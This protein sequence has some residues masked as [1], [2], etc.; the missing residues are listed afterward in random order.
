MRTPEL[1]RQ[2][3][4]I[5][6]S[7]V[8]FGGKHQ[9]LP[10]PDPG[11]KRLS[12]KGMRSL[13]DKLLE[14][15]RVNS[16][17]ESV[18]LESDAKS[19]PCPTLICITGDFAE[20]GDYSEFQQARQFLDQLAKGMGH[21]GVN[22]KESFFMVP[23][24]HDVGFFSS[25]IGERWHK[26]IQ[27]FN[28]FY[29]SAV[30]GSD[31]WSLDRVHDRI[32]DIGVVVLCINSEIYVQ[33][34]SPDEQRGQVDEEQ[35]A[36]IKRQLKGIKKK[37]LESAVRIA[38]IHHHPVLI[39][40]LAESY[41]GYD[42]VMRSGQLLNILREYGFHIVLHGHKHHPLTFP[43]DVRNGLEAVQDNP[44]LIVAGGSVGSTELPVPSGVNCYNQITIKWHPAAE[45]SRIRIVTR[46]LVTHDTK[47]RTKLLTREWAW[48]TLREDDRSFALNEHTVKPRKFLS[49]ISFDAKNPDL[50]ESVR[51]AEYP[52]TRRNFPV[53]EVRPSLEPSQA[54]E[55]TF[56]IESHRPEEVGWESPE[57]VTWTAGKLFP[58]FRIRRQDDPRFCASF[59]YWGP[60]LVQARLKF[61]DGYVAV[62]H[63][64]ARIPGK[65]K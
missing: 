48:E 40:A 20:T 55:A 12:S 13:A 8:H 43:E 30:R 4:I 49:S 31:P 10:E 61:A 14:D 21:L 19:L 51:K 28:E 5:H 58:V 52:R 62:A 64:Y 6:L 25:D 60:M 9:F 7:D 63:V 37:R 22:N 38:L 47:T 45:Q 41:K 53:V 46:R 32:R 15:L 54:Y 44:M 36:N 57:E 39:P 56:W 11:G 27:F 33:K 35:L 18:C 24:N 42:A 16:T 50:A 29:G 2:V 34:G 59:N 26:Y 3:R 23:G 17:S 1:T 65:T